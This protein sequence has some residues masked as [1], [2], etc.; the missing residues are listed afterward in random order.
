MK[1]TVTFLDEDGDVID[2]GR[3]ETV[4]REDRNSVTV[5]MYRVSEGFVFPGT[6]SVMIELHAVG[7]NDNEKEG[8]RALADL[9]RSGLTVTEFAL[10]QP[11][12][13]EVFL[14]LTGQKTSLA[15]GDA[16]H[17]DELEEVAV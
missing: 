4:T 10:G 15:F 16:P 11:S 2:S 3:L 12:L 6:R 5:L 9:A 14:A 7:V 13:D 8:V 1:V 17:T